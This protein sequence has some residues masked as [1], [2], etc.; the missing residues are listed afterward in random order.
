MN[1]LMN[2][3]QQTWAMTL[4]MAPYLLL[5]FAIAGVLSVLV[6]PEMV[7]RWLGGR[8]WKSVVKATL[9]GVPLPLC[10]CGVI[11]VAASLRKHGASKG[12]TTAFLAST[13][14]TGVDS[15]AATWGMM[16]P[17]FAG[18]RVMVALVTGLVAGA[19]VEK[20]ADDSPEASPGTPKV[21]DG[22]PPQARPLSI[23]QK[24]NDAF[25]F[26]FITLPR[27][28]ALSLT[29]GLLI[30]GVISAVVPPDSLGEG[31]THGIL[32]YLAITA[33]AIPMYVCST[34]S[35]PLA[36]G[37]MHAG[38]SPGA[39]LVFLIAGPAT[40]AATITTMSGLLGKR[41]IA[42]YLASII[43]CSWLAGFLLDQ[44]VTTDAIMSGHAA[45]SHDA[46]QGWLSLNLIAAILLVALLGWAL[47]T[48]LRE[49]LATSAQSCC[50]SSDEGCCSSGKCTSGDQ[51]LTIEVEGMTCINCSA[52]I[53]K[54]LSKMTGVSSVVANAKTG[55]VE[56]HGRDLDEVAL[57]QKIIDLGFECS[58]NPQA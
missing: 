15:I 21:T 8:G 12:A 44:F 18:I 48:R 22:T 7:Q 25:T 16:G 11:P 27:D 35:I 32:A 23:G 37:L 41:A 57:R 38:F 2:V 1:T 52:S 6:K 28:L 58:A 14:E 40:N 9:V 54:N 50:C 47:F 33:I 42:L 56:V 4:E 3:L 13:P 43:G 49:R 5:G 34:G 17:L 20:F 39:A 46:A 31:W 26:G 29:L 53:K 55:L 45:H 30:A 10:S 36:Y 19:L 51:R 24:L